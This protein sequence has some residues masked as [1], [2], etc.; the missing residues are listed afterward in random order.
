MVFLDTSVVV[1]LYVE[2]PKS[3]KAQKLVA[4]HDGVA[5][6][7]LAQVE[8]YSAIARLVRLKA[9]PSQDAQR[10]LESFEAHIAQGVYQF[11]PVTQKVYDLARDWIGSFETSL[12]SLDALHLAVAAENGLL[13]ATA[14]RTLAKAAKRLGVPSESI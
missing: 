13:F 5:I 10:V 2:E 4:R 14:D 9:M 1:A 3:T 12:R 6:C 8:F 7:P 11:H